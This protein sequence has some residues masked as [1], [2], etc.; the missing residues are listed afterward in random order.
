MHEFVVQFLSGA[1]NVVRMLVRFDG[2]QTLVL[3]WIWEFTRSTGARGGKFGDPV[4]VGCHLARPA[5]AARLQV[6]CCPQP[7]R[8]VGLISSP[9]HLIVLTPFSVQQNCLGLTLTPRQYTAF[10]IHLC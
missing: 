3:G 4:A 10:C 8:I 5:E 2:S 9:V 7:K 6:R 1:V